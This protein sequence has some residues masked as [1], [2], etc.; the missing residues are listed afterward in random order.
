MDD[1]LWLAY[2][3]DLAAFLALN[4][5]ERKENKAASEGDAQG[6]VHFSDSEFAS[7]KGMAT[8]TAKILP[9]GTFE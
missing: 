2:D 5:A 9:D 6:E 1:D 4:D 3:F 7:V 8:K